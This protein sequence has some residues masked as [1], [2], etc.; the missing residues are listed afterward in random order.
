MKMVG[1]TTESI[2]RRQAIVDEDMLVQAG[3]KS[4][5]YHEDSKVEVKS[6]IE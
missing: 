3:Q 2:H 5:A 4:A 6:E 1:H